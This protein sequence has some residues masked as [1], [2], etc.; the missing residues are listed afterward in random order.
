MEPAKL[1]A[2][3]TFYA[4]IIDLL[5]LRIEIC[6][7]SLPTCKGTIDLSD[8]EYCTNP[9]PVI[10]P[11]PVLYTISTRNKDPITWTGY[12]CI[13][14]LS[15]KEISTNFL[16]AH[17]TIFSKQVLKVSANDCWKSAQYPQMCDTTPMTKEGDTLK[18]LKEPE[19]KGQWMTTQS[20]TAKNCVTQIIKLRK[21]CQN[22]PVTSPFGIIANSSDDEFA[23][24]NDLTIVWHKPDATQ[25]PDCSIKTIF[26]GSGNLTKGATQSKLEDPVAQ[27][28]IIFYNNITKL[29]T[30]TSAFPIMGIPDTYIEISNH[31]SRSKR[32]VVDIPTGIIRL[33]QN[34]KICLT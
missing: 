10:Q 15:Q 23:T 1:L 32:S 28:E 27:L 29:C 20:F 19:G 18:S 33:A 24:H 6:N 14:W 30:N 2:V 5:A 12:T 21:E 26:Y 31:S 8:P 4:S 16:L 7:C 22:Y 13:Q 25:E 3:L 11:V 9:I 17:D 34:P